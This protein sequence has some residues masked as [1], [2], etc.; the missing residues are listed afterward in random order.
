VWFET[1]SGRYV[2]EVGE[3]SYDESGVTGSSSTDQ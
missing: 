1:V 2:D 3:E